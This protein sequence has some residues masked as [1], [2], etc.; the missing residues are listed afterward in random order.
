V[1]APVSTPKVYRA[2]TTV[3]TLSTPKIHTAYI[4]ETPE[5]IGEYFPLSKDQIA[6]AKGL[7]ISE[8]RI[9]EMRNRYIRSKHIL[10]TLHASDIYKN[11]I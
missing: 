1:L 7:D 3:P 6:R 2:Y 4:S 8:E 10:N 9:G 11:F 5:N